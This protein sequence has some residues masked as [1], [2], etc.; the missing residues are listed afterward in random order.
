MIVCPHTHTLFHNWSLD[1]LFTTSIIKVLCFQSLPP[2]PPLFPSLPFLLPCLLQKLLSRQPGLSA[3][4]TSNYSPSVTLLPAS[5]T[6]SSS[7]LLITLHSCLPASSFS[8]A[9]SSAKFFFTHTRTPSS[10]ASPLPLHS[11]SLQS[12]LV[13]LPTVSDTLVL[14]QQQPGTQVSACMTQLDF[15]IERGIK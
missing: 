14:W 9:F 11:L 1:I 10:L 12:F 2:P 13:Q 5:G 4:P 7:S 6:V 8:R 15:L 3:S